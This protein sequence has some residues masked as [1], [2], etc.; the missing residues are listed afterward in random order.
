M[1]ETEIFIKN[2]QT[3]KK[4]QNNLKC[5]VFLKQIQI[6]QQ[7]SAIQ[8]FLKIELDTSSHPVFRGI[9]L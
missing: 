6:T 2:Y 9:L 4:Q 5:P 7:F 1:E 8:F 3:S